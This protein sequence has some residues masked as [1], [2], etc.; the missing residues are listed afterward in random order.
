MSTPGNDGGSIDLSAA[1]AKYNTGAAEYS[2]IY[3][4]NYCDSDSEA[5]ADADA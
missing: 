5:D 2:H 3:K 4:E 1:A